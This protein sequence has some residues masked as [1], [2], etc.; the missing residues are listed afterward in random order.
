MSCIARGSGVPSDRAEGAR[1]IR[2]AAEQGNREA[3]FRYGDICE[4][5]LG[6]PVDL[7]EAAEKYRRAAEHDVFNAYFEIGRMWYEGRGVERNYAQAVYWYRRGDAVGNAFS[8]TLARPPIRHGVA[9]PDGDRGGCGA[10]VQARRLSMGHRRSAV[11]AWATCY[12]AGRGVPP[13]PG[14]SGACGATERPLEQGH[15]EAQFNL[16]NIYAAGRGV[17]PD[18]AEA[19]HWYR[20]AAERGHNGAIANL[21]GIRLQGG[22]SRK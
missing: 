14:R 10:L 18:L 7:A 21:R 2:R 5:G 22:M 1:W 17:P 6:V 13:R 8:A 11:Q 12:T 15:G 9:T 16:G 4:L 3:Q 20:K 19:A